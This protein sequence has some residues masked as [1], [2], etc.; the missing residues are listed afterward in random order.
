MVESFNTE[1]HVSADIIWLFWLLTVLFIVAGLIL[2]TFLLPA[3]GVDQPKL[4]TTPASQAAADIEAE[5]SPTCVT[6]GWCSI[7]DH[8]DVSISPTPMEA[9]PVPTVNASSLHTA[10]LAMRA[11]VTLDEDGDDPMTGRCQSA[12]ADIEAMLSGVEVEPEPKGGHP[13][14]LKLL[15]EMRELHVRKAADYG[16]G[17]DPFANVRA[18]SEFGIPAWVGVMVRAGDK[19][20]RIKSFLAN[21]NLKNESVED[22]LKDLAAYALIALVLYRETISY[23]GDDFDHPEGQSVSNSGTWRVPA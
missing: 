19:L 10:L 14:Y 2:L 12:I 1:V 15:D 3:P 6:T 5:A 17:A 16:R 9:D 11:W 20:H 7:P 23:G 22:S 21:G 18:S 8:F 13:E 4:K